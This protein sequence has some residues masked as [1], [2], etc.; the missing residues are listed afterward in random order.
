MFVELSFNLIEFKQLRPGERPVP[1]QDPAPTK[2]DPKHDKTSVPTSTAA[3]SNPA[4][5]AGQ[6]KQDPKAPSEK[7]MRFIT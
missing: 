7:R 4:P 5:A 2:P 3:R 1:I 6:V